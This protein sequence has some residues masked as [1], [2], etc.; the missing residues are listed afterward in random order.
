MSLRKLSMELEDDYWFIETV[1][2]VPKPTGE[3][4]IDYD[5]MLM[6]KLFTKS[7]LRYL[8]DEQLFKSPYL[9]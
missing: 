4:E 3:F 8:Y 6:K 9:T 5:Y 1:G 2:E 7:T